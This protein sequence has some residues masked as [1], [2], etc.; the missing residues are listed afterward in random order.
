MHCVA[1]HW[2]ADCWLARPETRFLR[3]SGSFLKE[4]IRNEL[5]AARNSLKNR[6]Q[7]LADLLFCHFC[8]DM[9]SSWCHWLSDSWPTDAWGLSKL[10]SN[11]ESLH[12][13]QFYVPSRRRGEGWRSPA[14]PHTPPLSP[15]LHLASL[16]GTPFQL[17]THVV[18]TL[19]NI[20]TSQCPPRW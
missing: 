20:F 10:R 13:L 12:L 9:S 18:V 15:S 4:G 19:F 17:R 11:F 2:R 6:L 5:G 1:Q 8:T 14:D 3:L 16:S 7:V